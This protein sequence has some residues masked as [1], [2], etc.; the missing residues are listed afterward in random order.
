MINKAMMI[1][2]MAMLF[3]CD[4]GTPGKPREAIGSMSTYKDDLHGVIC[5]QP[6]NNNAAFDCV[7]ISRG[8]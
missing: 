1:I 7:K 8:E 2:A 6:F 5:Y 4:N 3:G